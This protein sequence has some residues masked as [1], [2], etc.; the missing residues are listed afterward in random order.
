MNP[1]V[2]VIL[3]SEQ[4]GHC[5]NMRGTGRLLSK[6]EIKSSGKQPNIPGGYHYDAA[7]MKKLITAETETPKVKVINIHF[8]T[9]EI[10][11]GI[12]DISVFTLESDNM[13]V[14]QTMLKEKD[15]KTQM[16]IYGIAENGKVIANSDVSTPWGEIS[17]SYI[18]INLGMYAFFY[19]SLILFE[20]KA[21]T[22]GI[23]NKAP[24]YGYLNG[25]DTNEKLPYG[26]I[27]GAQP[28][29]LEWSKFLK[30]FFDGTKELVGVPKAPAPV[31][32][33][34]VQIES[35][36]MKTE[37]EVKVKFADEQILEVENKPKIRASTPGA[38]K[39]KFKLYVV[40]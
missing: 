13:T 18:P 38:N 21:W 31:E 37:T 3:T 30:Q 28:R 20:G 2:A 16:S 23:N 32:E 33:V 7:F 5:R 14:K 26:A 40:E 4:C 22:E 8:K 25:F 1:P 10:N 36:P 29:T 24:I 9:F 11:K 19:P 27:P 6:N 17:N 34:K 15:G 35:Q 12:M 39:F